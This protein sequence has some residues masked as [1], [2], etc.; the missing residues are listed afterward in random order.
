MRDFHSVELLA[1]RLFC[2]ISMVI[3][4]VTIALHLGLVDVGQWAYD[5][6]SIISS[7]RDNG[8][9]AFRDRLIGWSPRPISELLIWAYACLVNWTHKPLIG[10]FLGLLWLTLI[11]VPLISF[12][13]IRKK[14]PMDSGRPLM[15]SSLFTFGLV[16]LFL[17]GH[18]PGAL[19][20]S[21]VVAAAYLTTLSAITLCFVE[22]ALNMTAH[23]GGRVIAALSLIFAAASSE[24]GAIFVIVFGCLSVTCMSVDKFRNSVYQRQFLWCL[25]PTFIGIGVFV[26]LIC[27]R[28]RAQEALF[29]TVEYH[30]LYMTCKTAL[31]QTVKEYLVNGQRLST[32]GVFLGL[33]LKACFFLGVRYCWLSGGIKVPRRQVLVVFALSIVATTYFSV[34]AS[35]YGYGGLTN[36][37]HQELRQCLV[38]LFIA[39]IALFSCHYHAPFYDLRRTEWLGVIFVFITLVLVV[40]GRFGAL[41]HD[42][43]NYP[44]FIQNRNKS[45]NSGLSDGDAMIWFSPPKGQVADTLLFV[46]GI[47]NLES[48]APGVL[49]IMHFFH[50]E[51][52]E[53]RPY[54][55]YKRKTSYRYNSDRQ[56]PS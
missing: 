7:Y 22:V 28:A 49:D 4:L 48:K 25:L 38:M 23:H 54:H 21:P 26:L 19:F 32:R 1:R 50:K 8:W 56:Y 55:L 17:L 51:R 45:W 30:N 24:T 18:S 31:G 27:N 43:R 2:A 3:L 10:V 36:P 14:I 15:F 42:Y 41:I 39:T 12:F 35:Y 34:A 16:A 47:Y 52:L 44:V 40:R 33:L 29:A 20:Y 6:F 46:P 37:W 9:T 11:S 13:Q 53:I 5:E